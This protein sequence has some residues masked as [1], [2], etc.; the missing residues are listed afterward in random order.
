MNIRCFICLQAL[1]DK[2]FEV[3]SVVPFDIQRE[4]I[5]CIPEVVDDLQH[6]DIADQLK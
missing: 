3:M 1:V 5:A 4:I 2:M 6:V